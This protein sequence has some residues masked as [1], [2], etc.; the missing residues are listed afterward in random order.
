[1][2]PDFD[3]DI[4][5]WTAK[6]PVG[7]WSGD[8]DLYGYCLNNPIVLIDPDGFQTRPVP[9]PIRG[10]DAGATQGGGYGVR[11]TAN[12]INYPHS[13]VDLLQPQGGN[14]VAPVSGTIERSGPEGV[15]I[16]RQDGTIACNGVTK[17]K[18]ICWRLIHISPT[19]TSGNVT[20]G[21]VV[22][23]ILPQ[24]NPIPPHVH[25][26]YYELTCNGMSR[27]DPTPHL[28]PQP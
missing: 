6:D 1:M 25:V 7:F 23:T 11:R 4:G 21:Q 28:P 2:L 20:E 24:N 13:G 10:P 8:T 27:S 15:M 14:V 9:G 26:E 5:R 16:C 18:L 22:G 3:P 17:S 12:G 19:V